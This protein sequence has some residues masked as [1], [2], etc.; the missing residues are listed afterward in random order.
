MTCFGRSGAGRA[1]TCSRD[2]RRRRSRRRS[3]RCTR[4]SR[5]SARGL[6]RSWSRASTQPRGRTGLL[7][8]RERGV[9]AAGRRRPV[10]SP[11][12]R[13]AVDL[14]ADRQVPRHRD[15][16][17]ARRRQPRPGGGD[18]RRARPAFPSRMTRTSS[19]PKCSKRTQ[20]PLRP[21]ARSAGRLALLRSD[22][23][24][25]LSERTMPVARA[26]AALRSAHDTSHRPS[27]AAS[28]G[29]RA[30]GDHRRHLRAWGW[31]W[32]ASSR[33]VARAWRSS[34]AP[35]AASKR[36]RAQ[37]P[38]AHGIV[39][40]VARKGRHLSDRA[41]DHRGTRRPRRAGQ[42]RVEPGSDAAGAARR[43]RV[44]R[45]RTGAGDQR[46]RAVPAD[47]GAARRAGRVGARGPRRRRAQRLERRR[48][49]RRIRSG[50]RTAR[51]RPRCIT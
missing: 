51:A 37:H 1:A 8:A 2:R 31:R 14:G 27:S 4:A 28:P 5:T 15:L 39:G 6:P 23:C 10:E 43:H 24:A 47:Q 25:A 26:T 12:R 40:D 49:Q 11:D 17:Q 42:Q 44:R 35:R 16:Q 33:A 3:G 50:A 20:S 34:R 45:L 32:C 30:R 7:S 48:D 36:S 46:A 13:D 21:R 38:G 41:A 22:R 29:R 18:R 9:A 19:R